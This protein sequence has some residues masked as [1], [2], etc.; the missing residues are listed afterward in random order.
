MAATGTQTTV[1]SAIEIADLTQAGGP[2]DGGSTAET[3][4][5]SL[6]KSVYLKL[7]SASFSFFVAGVNDGAIG[8]LIPYFIREHNVSTA[9]VSS[10][11]GANFLGWLFAAFANTHLYQYLNLGAMLALG[12]A[13]QI[14]AHALRSWDPPFG[15]FVVTFWVVSVGQAFQDTHANSWV[16][17]AVPKGAHRWLAF[18]HAMY[19]AGCLVGPFVATAVASAG[20]FSRW[21]LFY[22]FP[23]GLGA[24]NLVL[25]CVAF[26]DTL[27]LRRRS[28]ASDEAVSRNKEAAQLIKKTAST[29]SVWLL[30]LFFFFYLGAVLTAGGWVVEYL[31]NVRHGNLSQMGYVPAASNGGALLG[32]L[33]LAEPTHGFGE[34]RMVFVYIVVSI[35]LQLIFWL[36]PNIIAASIAVSFI[37]FF[38]GPLF[39]TGISLGSKLF[40]SEIHSTALPLVFVFAQLGGSLF[41]I[42]T[43]VVSADAG[44]KVL[45]PMLIALLAITAIS[46]LLVPAPKTSNAEL[47][48][49]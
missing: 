31:V 34:R 14:A 29:P 26:R 5:R 45:Q 47:H 12:A 44:V 1:E 28:F 37:G 39:P 3:E 13:F 36:V 30:S 49:E 18:I 7:I 40:P 46:W 2:Q 48:Q 43:G 42:I 38:T 35:G 4:S 11:Y 25:T 6:D 22:T 21:Y 10:V 19:M 33:L 27:G 20:E 32:R 23:L 41:P 17:G 15:L 24:V 16:A 8:A 9:I